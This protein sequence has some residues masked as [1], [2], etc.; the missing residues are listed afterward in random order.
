MGTVV[1]ATEEVLRG[2]KGMEKK[3]EMVLV[4]GTYIFILCSFLGFPGLGIY[5][6]HLDHF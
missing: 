3:L 6:F 2:G 5:H 4:A 1:Q